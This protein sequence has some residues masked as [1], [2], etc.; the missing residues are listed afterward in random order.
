MKIKQQNP[1]QPN[2]TFQ[3][4]LCSKSFY[5]TRTGNKFIFNNKNRIQ[6]SVK[7]KQP[8]ESKENRFLKNESVLNFNIGLQYQGQY[9]FYSNRRGFL[10]NHFHPHGL[11]F[12]LLLPVR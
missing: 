8:W 1:A 12:L 7:V 4:P 11:L 3:Y 10:G 2:L 9:T 6:S 5:T